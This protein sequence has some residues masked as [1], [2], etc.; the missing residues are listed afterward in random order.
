[1]LFVHRPGQRDIKLA[2]NYVIGRYDKTSYVIMIATSVVVTSA[3][4]DQ[5]YLI[6]LIHD[7]IFLTQ[8]LSGLLMRYQGGI[9]N[10]TYNEVRYDLMNYIGAMARRHLGDLL[11][12]YSTTDDAN[13]KIEMGGSSA[14]CLRLATMLRK[15][16]AA[17]IYAAND[18]FLDADGQ[19]GTFD[20]RVGR[21]SPFIAISDQLEPNG[22][23]NP[24]LK[25]ING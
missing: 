1:M 21:R 8:T 11:I 22:L 13:G 10:G 20:F 7:G 23:Y 2:R 17:F 9:N 15:R 14:D 5:Y 3:A 16:Y 4:T 25:G 24:S 19:G 18:G 6:S 12:S